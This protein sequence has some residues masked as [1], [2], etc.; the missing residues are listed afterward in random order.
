MSQINFEQ[1]LLV[2]N[3]IEECRG[4]ISF[5]LRF[6]DTTSGSKKIILSREN[7]DGFHTF[8]A[9]SVSSTSGAT[10]TNLVSGDISRVKELTFN[11]TKEAGSVNS[12]VDFNVLLVVQES[13][14]NVIKAEIFEQDVLDFITVDCLTDATIEPSKTPTE[15]PTPTLTEGFENV[16]RRI[17]IFDIDKTLEIGDVV[18]SS[19][20][21][22]DTYSLEEI[23][24]LNSQYF[25]DYSVFYVRQEKENVIYKIQPDEGNSDIL[26]VVDFEL[27]PTQTPTPSFTPTN[28]RT[29]SNT[30]TNTETPT[31]TPTYTPT[32]TRS[33]TPT[34]T[35]TRSVTPTSTLTNTPTLTSSQTPP[36]T[37]FSYYYIASN[38]QGLCY[39][40][41]TLIPTILIYDQLLDDEVLDVN[42]LLPKKRNAVNVN[43]W[44]GFDEIKN[45]LPE[46][47][48]FTSLYIRKTT[49]SENKI[50][51]INKTVGTGQAIVVSNTE[52]PF[53]V[54][55][56]PTQTP[57]ST[58]TATPTNTTTPTTTLTP[59][60]TPS[61][62]LDRNVFVVLN[63]PSEYSEVVNN[64][65]RYVHIFNSGDNFS[66]NGIL[67]LNEPVYAE[68]NLEFNDVDLASQY[69]LQS[70]RS[71]LDSEDNQI[72]YVYSLDSKKFYELKN[73][74][75]VLVVSAELPT[76]TATPTSSVTST[77]QPTP[78]PSQTPT[79]SP[80]LTPLPTS[81]ANPT[82][83][84]TNSVTPTISPTNSVT[85]TNTSTPGGTPTPTPTL[86]NTPTNS[87]TPT[88]PPTGTPTGTVTPVMLSK[89]IQISL[90]RLEV[91]RNYSVEI[92][93]TMNSDSEVRVVPTIQNII[94][95]SHTQNIAV[96]L[97]FSG[98]IS[99]INLSIRVTDTVNGSVDYNTIL[100]YTNNFQ[101]CY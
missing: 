70:F 39:G 52:E 41:Q 15:T 4:G 98:S 16:W 6:S 29:P 64:R 51:V 63:R 71:V 20:L 83:T 55:Q 40:T 96:R 86:T 93:D 2:A 42:S 53:C 38:I 66:V 67:A 84:P 43:D 11:F 37:D 94:A 72:V 56:T 81:T 75:N 101:E 17:P 19:E 99:I 49:D 45:R 95:S 58:L 62:V 57:S 35:L 13:R 69:T 12:Y 9:V 44:W 26:R 100:V 23:R 97:D 14:F 25:D 24:A 80:P 33:N 68:T 1:S 28:S 34:Q 77:T 60:I 92:L 18:Y 74:Q 32:V 59:S 21:A 8:G 27:C 46:T 3:S 82:G 87:K 73:I 36:A 61:P 5:V 31:T 22:K 78:T 65:D 90:N 91:G 54:T 48:N 47:G 7:T 50:I 10:V 79:T 30:P 89:V 76:P 88:P 85:P